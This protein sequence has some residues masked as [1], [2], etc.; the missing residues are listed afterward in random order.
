[1]HGG[2]WNFTGTK[3]DRAI[4]HGEGCEGGFIVVQRQPNLLQVI[5]ALRTTSSLTS[6]LDRGQQ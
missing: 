5:L 4:T 6:L 1:M 3:I 2:L